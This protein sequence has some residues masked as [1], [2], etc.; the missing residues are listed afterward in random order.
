MFAEWLVD[1]G[2]GGVG[3]GTAPAVVRNITAQPRFKSDCL[4]DVSQR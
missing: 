1:A 4:I 2:A 3:D